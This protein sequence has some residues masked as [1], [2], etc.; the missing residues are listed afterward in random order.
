MENSN[1][2]LCPALCRR[3]HC[4]IAPTSQA[5]AECQA[6]NPVPST[7]MERCV[8]RW[9]LT[10]GW[11]GFPLRLLILHI[12]TILGKYQ[13][14]SSFWSDA[15]DSYLVFRWDSDITTHTTWNISI[16]RIGYKTPVPLFPTFFHLTICSVTFHYLSYCSF[17]VIIF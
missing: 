15:P 4:I 6:N 5:M 17:L 11:V 1:A 12:V 2:F 14:L 7:E 3:S 13:S 10:S 8:L 9:L 16:R